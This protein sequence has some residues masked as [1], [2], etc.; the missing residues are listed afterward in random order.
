MLRRLGRGV[1]GRGAARQL[2]DWK[3]IEFLR[4]DPEAAR[5]GQDYHRQ[6]TRLQPAEIARLLDALPYLHA[7]EL[8]TLIEDPIAADT[9]ETM[10]PERQ[11]Q[12]IQV[13]DE[14]QSAR[15]LTL[16]APESA[17]DLLGSL[18]PERAQRLLQ[19]VA[20]P[21]RDLIVDLLRYPEDTAGG[22]MTNQLVCVHAT[23]TV[24]AA[25]RDLEGELCSRNFA[26]YLYVI[27]SD[28]ER[29]LQGVVTLRDFAVADERTPIESLMRPQMSSIDALEP[30]TSAARQV[31][32]LHLAALPVT[33]RDGRLLGAVTI[34]MAIAQ[35]APSSWRELAPRVFS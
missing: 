35:I 12:V 18:L 14:D 26:N 32:D 1:L 31:A 8:L 4:G 21:Q 10:S 24:G 30:A 13:L 19:R 29:H 27:D 16:M 7:A 25:R 3:D 11:A 9:L 33:S 23:D 5:Q 28:S 15:L 2:V 6:I 20:E 34:A 22:I 17:A